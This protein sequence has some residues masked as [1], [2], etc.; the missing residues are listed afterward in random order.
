MIKGIKLNIYKRMYVVERKQ[1]MQK[2]IGMKTLKTAVGASV[3]IIIAQFVGMEYAASA[4]IITILSIQNTRRES[5]KLAIRRL[6]A[7][8]IALFIGTIAFLILEFNSISFGVYLLIF[9]PAA[10]KLKVTEGIAPASVLVTH[11]LGEGKITYPIIT[12]EIMIM[13]VGV[14]VAL[15]VNLYM[16]SLEE[17]LLTQKSVIEAQMYEIFIKM[18]EALRSKECMLDIGLEL[19]ALE[20][21]LK[22]AMKRATQYRNNSF[23]GKKSLYEKY[24]EMRYLQYQVMLYMQKHFEHFYMI[25]KEA[26]E[27]AKLTEKLAESVHGR[28]LVEELL[29]EVERLRGYFKESELPITRDEFENRAMLYQFL[30]DIEQYLRV[31]KQFKDSLNEKERKEYKCY[32]EVTENKKNM[33]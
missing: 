25:A 7:T 1:N 16:P 6:I 30:S 11:L 24:F 28:V 23:I 22:Q 9:I 12:N 4:G 19:N 10:S 26:F 20:N 17:Q 3:A 14:G 31:K 33:S 5:V 15:I 2:I 8:C 18:S 13:L 27:I 29:D 21:N 32:Y